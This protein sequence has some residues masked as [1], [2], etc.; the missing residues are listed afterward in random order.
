MKSIRVHALEGSMVSTW[1]GIEK[2]YSI[3]KKEKEDVVKKIDEVN[4]EFLQ[5]NE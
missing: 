4:E 2:L 5:E 3:H 1:K